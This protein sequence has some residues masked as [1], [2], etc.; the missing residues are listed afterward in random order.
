M[1]KLA[2]LF[3]LT[4]FALFFT[5]GAWAQVLPTVKPEEVG[6]S[7]ERLARIGQM[8]TADVEITQMM[9]NRGQLDGVR[10]LSRKTVEYMTAD[11]LGGIKFRPGQ[12][13]GLGISVRKEPG[14]AG[15][16]GSVGEYTWGGFGGTFFWVDPKEDLIGIWMA[17]A[18]GQLSYYRATFKNLVLQAVAD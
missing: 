2:S 10:L 16:P 6:L 8:V 12:G 18:P 15:E 4:T 13:F 3:A 17:Q 11:Q 9:L 1:K 14:V 5:A 7:S